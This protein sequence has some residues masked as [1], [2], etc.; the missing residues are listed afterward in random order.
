MFGFRFRMQPMKS[1]IMRLSLLFLLALPILACSTG[2]TQTPA[3][4]TEA[5]VAPDLAPDQ[6]LN[7]EVEGEVT[8]E[9]PTAT[10]VPPVKA[11][12][13]SYYTVV[14]TS[15]PVVAMTF[16]D[17]PHKTNTPRLLDILKERNIKAT[18]F[19]VGQNVAEY[20][21]IAKRIVDEGHEIANH[22]WSHA[23]LTKL[24]DSGVRRELQK[25]ASVI[26]STTG[27]RPTVFRPPYGALSK[28]QRHWIF[29]E[30]D[31]PAI[32]WTVD[33]L[34]WK[35]PGVSV[36]TSRIVNGAKPGAIILA[37]DIHEP[38]ITAMPG[39]LDQLLAKGYRFV[40]VSEL[41]AMEEP[42]PTATPKPVATATVAP[43]TRSADL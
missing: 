19:V 36:V 4:T 39:T 29:D 43:E 6:S 33:P 11:K 32:I 15:Q 25:T 10:P 42:V 2:V 12:R 35:R 5:T 31:Y 13:D 27:V 17:G 38:T 26:E 37:H 30:F 23:W 20:P 22:T 8:V 24:S 34:D 21:E 18:F 1:L 14:R 28:R 3:K 40:T 7:L 16:D 9:T 41:I